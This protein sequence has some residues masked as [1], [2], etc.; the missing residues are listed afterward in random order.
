[1]TMMNGNITYRA[2]NEIVSSLT[3]G[4]DGSYQIHFNTRTKWSRANENNYEVG[5]LS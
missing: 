4:N 5:R 2:S 1:M 3:E